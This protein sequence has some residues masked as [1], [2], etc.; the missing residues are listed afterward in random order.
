MRR[1]GIIMASLVVLL[2]ATA[3][4]TWSIVGVDPE[5]GEVGVAVAS[6]VQA[7]FGST[8]LP[9]VAGLAPGIGAL[10]A[11][12]QF[13]QQTRDHALDLLAQGLEPQAILDMVVAADFGSASRQYGVVTL[14][15]QTATWTGSSA[16]AWAGALQGD[17]VTAQGNILY[18]L[19]VVA[20]ALATF[21]ADSR[22]CPFTLADRLMAALEAG[23]AKGGDNR[24]S[25]EQSALAAVIMV[26]KPSD[27]MDAPHLDLRIPSQPAGGDNPVELLRALYDD[28]RLE[29]PPDDSACGGD[30]TGTDS[31]DATSMSSDTGTSGDASGG[32]EGSTTGREPTTGPDTPADVDGSETSGT[33]TEQDGAA[34]GCGCRAS[35]PA[36][37][38]SACLLLLAVACRRRAGSRG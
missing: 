37:P 19:E 13:S 29:H 3:G 27:E 14:D 6:C 25:E 38:A 33:H 12:A 5:T 35:T 30:E 2:P 22:T 32:D 28:W 34:D 23:A 26:A 18:G 20:D 36:L 11:Q 9:Q 4:A 1:L 17:H 10:A 21:E 24:C 15:G 8:I 7:P 31:G 16:L